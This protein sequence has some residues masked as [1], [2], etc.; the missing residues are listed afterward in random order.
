MIYF[1]TGSANRYSAHAKKMLYPL[2]MSRS[3]IIAELKTRGVNRGLTTLKAELLRDLLQAIKEGDTIAPPQLSKA[4]LLRSEVFGRIGQDGIYR[5]V[6][7]RR[8]SAARG[9]MAQY[10]STEELRDVLSFL[11]WEVP[12]LAWKDQLGALAVARLKAQGRTLGASSGAS[13]A[14]GAASPRSPTGR[15]AASPRS[16]SPARSPLAPASP[17]TTLRYY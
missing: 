5:I 14:R 13:G 9:K 3:A 4:A 15:G 11:G 10:M 2:K 16:A 7:K 17:R 1:T 12:E 8:N 6:D